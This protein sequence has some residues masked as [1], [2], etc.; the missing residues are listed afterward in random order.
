MSILKKVIRA[1][2]KIFNVSIKRRRSPKKKVL[3]ASAKK[4]KAPKFVP[5][6][7]VKS[8]PK[9]KTAA[10]K[11]TVASKPKLAKAKP[12]Q[13]P[14]KPVGALV[15]E[16]THYFDRIKVCV[17]RIDRDHIKKGDRLLIRGPKEEL[18]QN[19][20]SMQIENEDV[21]LAKKG[22][23]IGLKVI[24]PVSVKDAVYKL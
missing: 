10:K 16:V 14:S 2:K 19:V 13:T 24:K 23:L 20:T 15:G 21:S 22:Q 12:V 7:K 3:K 9:P 17:I 6:P 1:I 8:R 4:R 11:K 18:S 5:R